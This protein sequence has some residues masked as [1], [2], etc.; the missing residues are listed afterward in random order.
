[1]SCAHLRVGEQPKSNVN[2]TLGTIVRSYALPWQTLGA[3]TRARIRH[4][5]C[6]A[7]S[8][9]RRTLAPSS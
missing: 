1:M 9:D 5:A 3:P 7:Q 4:T 2:L 8:P 6:P